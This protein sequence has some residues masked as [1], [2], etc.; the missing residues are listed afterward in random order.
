MVQLRQRLWIYHSRLWRRRSLRSSSPPLSRIFPKHFFSQT[1]IQAQGFRSL[2][3]GEAVEFEIARGQDGR[4]RAVNVTG[5]DGAEPQ[6][7]IHHTRTSFTYSISRV[8]LV[9]DTLAEVM[10]ETVE[11]ADMAAVAATEGVAA[12]V[13]AMEG[14]D[15]AIEEA[16]AD[17]G[18]MMAQEMKMAFEIVF[19]RI[20]ER[21]ISNFERFAFRSDRRPARAVKS[22]FSS[23]DGT[24]P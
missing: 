8:S 18:E 7:S 17:L 9:D 1:N 14:V 21:M 16:M 10:V 5:P 2:R 11:E 12:I 19:K 24:L 15:I 23:T 4:T 6:V 20:L 22:A 3:E 13:A